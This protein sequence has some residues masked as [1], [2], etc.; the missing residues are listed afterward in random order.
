MSSTFAENWTTQ[1]RKGFLELCVMNI[2]DGRP[3]YGYDIVR[4]LRGI[5]ALV[6]S[7]GTVYPIL[8]RLKRERFVETSIEESPD[9]PP[10]KYYQLTDDGRHQ[11]AWMNDHWKTLEQGIETL[12]GGTTR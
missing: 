9:G 1:V 11:L 2:L 5:E 3:L 8:S 10:R 7:E 4:T 6:I 12:R